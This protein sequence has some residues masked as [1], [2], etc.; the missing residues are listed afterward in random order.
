MKRT[1][2][3][4][5]ALVAGG[6][7]SGMS[8]AYGQMTGKRLETTDS[9]ARQGVKDATNRLRVPGF[10]YVGAL[11]DPTWATSDSLA[12][13]AVRV[14]NGQWR[15]G[16]LRNDAVQ[17]DSLL[18]DDWT[19][20]DAGG[21]VQSK[22]HYLAD[23]RSG[24]RSYEFINDGETSVRIYGDTAVVTGHTTSKGYFKDQQTGGTSLFTRTYAMRQ[25]RWQMIAS[26]STLI[27][28]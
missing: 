21:V 20:T 22:A 5:A 25:G 13:Q 3:I 23:V 12:R 8:P 7:T 24:E 16:K 26:H 15:L 1:C 19:T 11:L 6:G 27:G 9:V 14:A 17:L 28:R 18:A 4:L 10:R 2:L